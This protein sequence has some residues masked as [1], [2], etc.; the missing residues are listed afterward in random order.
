MAERSEFLLNN[1][2]NKHKMIRTI[3]SA[4]C[5]PLALIMFSCVS[6]DSSDGGADIPQLTIAGGGDDGEMLVKNFNLGEE[7]VITPEITY[8]GGGSES[9]LKYEWSIGSYSNGSK[10]KLEAAGSEKELRHN[11]LEGGSYYAHL[12]VTDGKVGAV[13][14]YQIN[15]NRTFEE[16]YMLVSND[17][18]GNG[19]LAFI[20]I[21]T[22]EETAAG[23]PQICMEHCVERMNEGVE[24][25]RLVGAIHAISTW[26]KEVHRLL[27]SDEDRCLI[28]E[29]NTFVAIADLSYSDIYNGFKA[30]RFIP[31]Y[32][33]FAYDESG[34]SV[35]INTAN[36]FTF[37]SN[38]FKGVQFDD[39][40][41]YTYTMWGSSNTQLMVAK[42]NEGEILEYN[43]NYGKLM[44]TG[45]LL[46][47]ENIVTAFGFK[48]ESAYSASSYILTQSKED[49][50]KYYMRKLQIAYMSY[51]GT[52]TRSE[53]TASDDTAMPERGTRVVYS[54]KY[55]RFFY[56]IDNKI[57]VCLPGN[58][59]PL[60]LKTEYALSFSSDEAVTFINVNADTEELYIATYNSSTKRGNF[61]IY[62]TA[63]VRTDN[64]NKAVPAAEH[65]SVADKIIDVVYKP[66]L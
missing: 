45:D 19:N 63:D 1:I 51:Y 52:G 24:T 56:A 21:M 20:K 30:S 65:K 34:K 47:D 12:V 50:S 39:A 53:F 22:P 32:N 33:P 58:E 54:P 17:E 66:S 26:P 10:G 61:Y 57:Y 36:M 27:L 15:I 8:Q 42:Y 3:L 60:P 35:H 41:T 7:C 6:D 29:P 18:E 5:L 38:G 31:S 16:G 40:F 59:N 44:D 2:K 43:S 46:K 14:D 25:G 48:S 23:T 64:Q 55:D 11:F 9:E 13:M 62:S 49:V 37:E 4:L 28:L